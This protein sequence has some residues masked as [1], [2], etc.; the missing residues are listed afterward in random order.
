[1]HCSANVG[2]NGDV[3]IFFG[4]SGTGKT[5]LSADPIAVPHRR[6]RA[7][8]ERPRRLQHRGRLLREGDPPL[9]RRRAG[10]LPGGAHA[11]G[12]S[13]RTSTVDERGVLD[14]DD[15]SKTENTRAAYK[16]RQIPNALPEKRAGPPAQRRL[17][18]RRRLRHPAAARAARPR[19]GAVLL[20]VRLHGE[21]RGHRD[22]RHRAAADVL[23]VLRRAV[24]A[25]AADRLLADARREARALRRH[26]LARQHGLDGR[27]V[28]RGR[29]DADRR[30]PGAAQGGAVG[31]AGRTRSTAPTSSSASRCRCACRASTRSCS[32]RARRGATPRRTT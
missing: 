25:A 14:L 15:D 1:M 6:R 31:G 4:L 16:L 11:S 3:A 9:A 10:D 18:H 8:L 23:D 22:R 27:A 7:R 32:T 13:S 12:R 24:P 30:H 20:P 28:R 21:A 29:A 26:G 17:P 19:P 2:E 5:T